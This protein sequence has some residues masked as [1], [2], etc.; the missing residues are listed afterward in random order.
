MELLREASDQEDEEGK[1]GTRTGRVERRR[2]W[3]LLGAG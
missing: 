3:L 1:T 2:C